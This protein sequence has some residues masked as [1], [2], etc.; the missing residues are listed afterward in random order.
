MAL[1]A[2]DKSKFPPLRT[3]HSTGPQDLILESIG[4]YNQG[5]GYQHE[6]LGYLRRLV[7]AVAI[8]RVLPIPALLL[9]H[10]PRFD[11]GVLVHVVFVFWE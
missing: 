1:G 7:F 4:V 11:G 2:A 10:L 9:G 8:R 3:R 6:P 5:R